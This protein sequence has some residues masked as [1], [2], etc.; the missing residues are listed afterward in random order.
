[1]GQTL[2]FGLPGNPASAL[3]TFELFGRPALRALTGLSGS[4]RVVVRA[5][6]AAPQ[7]KPVELTVYLRARVIRHADGLFL[8]PLRTQASGNLTSTAGVGALAVLPAG[9]RRLAAGAAVDAILLEAPL[10]GPP[11]APR[12]RRR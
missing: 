10:D 1:M 6:L 7:E 12:G 11:A 3:T 9:R 8:H 4:G 5:R 2:V